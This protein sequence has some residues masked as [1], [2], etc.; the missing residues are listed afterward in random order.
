MDDK[1][2][3]AFQEAVERKKAEAKER[4][5]GPHEQNPAPEDTHER[6][7]QDAER[8]S[9]TRHGQVTADKWNQ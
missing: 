7:P 8:E 5:E 9:G 2:Q 3:Q 1:Q 4:S 6:P